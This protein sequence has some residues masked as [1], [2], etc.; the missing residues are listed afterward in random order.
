MSDL[1]NPEGFNFQHPDTK[2]NLSEVGSFL[3]GRII[4]TE[5]KPGIRMSNDDLGNT[6]YTSTS[7]T[8]ETFAGRL[9]CQL[10]VSDDGKKVLGQNPG[11]LQGIRNGTLMHK[12]VSIGGYESNV[13]QVPLETPTG[14]R[15]FALKYTFPLNLGYA[16]YHTSG[17]AAMRFMQLA[18]REKPI[19]H[20]RF[21]SPILATHNVTLTPFE[22]DGLSFAHAMD[23]LDPQDPHRDKAIENKWSLQ[24]PKVLAQLIKLRDMDSQLPDGERF[25]DQFIPTLEKSHYQLKDWVTQKIKTDQ[26]LQDFKYDTGDTTIRQSVVDIEKLTQLFKRFRGNAKMRSGNEEFDG[27]FLSSLAMVELGA[28]VNDI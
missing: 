20:V 21:L 5:G 25:Y 19:P 27:Q 13:Y 24:N 10:V 22:N 28:G 1:Q 4:N 3:E 17:I 2:P 18:E 23:Y 7:K 8:E 15:D 26:T 16:Q 11:L 12:G 14:S 6:V 9:P